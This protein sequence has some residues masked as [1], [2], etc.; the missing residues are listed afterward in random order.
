MEKSNHLEEV[1]EQ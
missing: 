1:K